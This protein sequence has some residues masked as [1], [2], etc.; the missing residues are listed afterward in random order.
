MMLRNSLF[1]ICLLV[2]MSTY[3]FVSCKNGEE[4][5]DSIP[6]GQFSWTEWQIKAGWDDY[7]ANE[8]TPNSSNVDELNEFTQNSNI[9]FII[10]TA[11]WCPDSK[12]ET[13]KIYKLCDMASIQLSN[14]TLYGVDYDKKEPSGK[15]A[16]FNLQKVPTLIV[17][18]DDQEIG[19][20]VEYP[21][22]SW[23]QDLVD[24]LSD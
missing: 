3:L 20:I 6:V 17:C 24:I 21:V 15:Y 9:T 2:V 5:D 16:D 19:R 12:S 10:F 1:Y 8:Y 14:V 13:P 11:S 22:N 4:S 23:D 18:V 7:S